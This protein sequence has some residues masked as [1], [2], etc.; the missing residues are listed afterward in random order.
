MAS[1]EGKSDSG[2][3]DSMIHYLKDI[4]GS[5]LF[6]N[7]DGDNKQKFENSFKSS[8]NII[9]IEKFVKNSGVSVLVAEQTA[10]GGELKPKKFNQYNKCL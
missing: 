3:C 6:I 5:I 4:C 1:D 2:E 7:I 8:Q 9:M 10:D